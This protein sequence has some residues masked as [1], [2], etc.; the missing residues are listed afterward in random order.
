MV[1]V[2]FGKEASQTRDY[3]V[4]RNATLRA[5]RPDPSLRRERL[6]QDDNQTA[7]LPNA[8]PAPI[9]RDC[10]H[11]LFRRACAVR[12]A[13]FH[14]RAVRSRDPQT[15]VI[16]SQLYRLRFAFITFIEGSTGRRLIMISVS[17]IRWYTLPSIFAFHRFS[18][19]AKAKSMSLQD[20]HAK[21]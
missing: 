1:V 12:P 6:L 8:D 3:C 9:R 15:I 7:P 5:A 4:A 16:R 10:P 11:R 14:S 2:Q 18:V 13:P 17:G 20:L 19:S 21:S